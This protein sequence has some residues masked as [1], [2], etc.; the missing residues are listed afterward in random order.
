MG[1]QL[2][3]ALAAATLIVTAGCGGDDDADAER[4]VLDNAR[5]LVTAQTA[6]R[7]PIVV[8]ELPL[9]DRSTYTG[10]NRVVNLWLDESG[11]PIA[12]DVWGR[13]TF[14]TGPILLADDIDFG[15]SSPYF[16]APPDYELSIVGA[17]AGPDGPELAGLIN[18][19]SSERLTSVFTNDDRRGSTATANLWEAGPDAPAPAAP[20]RAVIVV[21]APNTQAFRN[22]LRANVGADSFYVG[23]GRG[24]CRP[25]RR[26]SDGVQPE[27]LGGTSVV[28]LD[29]EPG[30]IVVSLHPWPSPEACATPAVAEVDVDAVAGESVLALAY[31]ADGAT[32]DWLLM[33]FG[34]A[35]S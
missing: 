33:P 26:E 16:A 5:D 22:E 6:E 9:P 29:V 31:T 11:E 32:F 21:A 28:E 18:A 4:S 3:G 24:E 2:V 23:D 8:D 25:Q 17:G 10:A 12:V 30:T 27:V 1:H 34:G 13:R 19:T 35:P 7:P 14:T 15:E 20:E